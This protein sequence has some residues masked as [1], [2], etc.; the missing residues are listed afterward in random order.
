MNTISQL[1]SLA[2]VDDC[3]TCSIGATRTMGNFV[4]AVFAALGKTYGYLTPDLWAETR[5]SK[6]PYAVCL[7]LPPSLPLPHPHR[8]TARCS[9][10]PSSTLRP[11]HRTTS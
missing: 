6:D 5:L 7:C 4:K 2:G 9:P 3:F 8:S 10:P 1:L 11:K